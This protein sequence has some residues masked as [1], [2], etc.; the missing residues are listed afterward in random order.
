[1]KK[2]RK[3]SQKM[4]VMASQSMYFGGVLVMLVVMVILNLLA[5][6]SCNQQL[7]AIG[8]KEKLLARLEKDRSRECARWDAMKGPED[9]DLA[10]RRFG[11]AM[12][13]PK[14][15]QIVMMDARGRPR[16]GQLSVARAKSRQSVAKTVRYAAPRRRW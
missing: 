12:R 4:S 1:M 10:L 13:Y 3:R 15:E 7:K 2:N 8:E 16:P 14:A 11:L 9:L 6:S 5:T